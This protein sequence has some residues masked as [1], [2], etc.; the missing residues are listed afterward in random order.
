MSPFIETLGWMLIHFLWQAAVIAV[1]LWIVTQFI[2]SA[3]WRYL[4]YCGSML[5]MLACAFVSVVM[6][7]PESKPTMAQA[8]AVA[9][10][11]VPVDM[12][13]TSQ[14]TAELNPP[15]PIN[16]VMPGESSAPMSTAIVGAVQDEIPL[17]MASWLPWVVA[18]WAV[19][20]AILS[21]N[22][23]RSW[24]ALRR[25][26]SLSDPDTNA[27][28]VSVFARLLDRMGLTRQVELRCS[29]KTS[30]PLVVGW[31]RPAVI[32]P[33]SL[34]ARMPSWQVEAIL[35]HELAHI[36]RHDYL[37]N[38][39]QNVVETIF[40]YH[41]AVWWVSNQIRKER[42][43]CCDDTAAAICGNVVDYAR[44]LTSLEE[45]RSDVP[46]GALS[47]ASGP[48]LGRVRRLLGAS[49]NDAA[50]AFSWP[51]GVAVA[52]LVAG[53]FASVHFVQGQEP[54]DAKDEKVDPT[55]RAGSVRGLPLY[56]LPTSDD[57]TKFDDLYDADGKRKPNVFFQSLGEVGPWLYY[58]AGAAHFYLSVRPDPEV[59]KDIVYGP[60]PGRPVE[61]LDLA[62]WLRES[63]N[64]PDPS[65][66]RRVAHRMIR[67]GD[68]SLAM[69]SF[70]WILTFEPPSPPREY[71]SL[72][73]EVTAYLR[74]H[75]GSDKAKA[76]SDQLARM[77]AESEIAWDKKREQLADELY[78]SGVAGS[79][80]TED[81][82]KIRWSE[83]TD[84][85]LRLGVAGVEEGARWR[86]GDTIVLDVFV[87]NSSSDPLRFA[88][89]PRID[90]GLSLQLTDAE[91]NT[92]Q[93]QITRFSGWI[94]HQ[95]GE[96]A[97]SEM[98]K[99]KSGAAFF[100]GKSEEDVRNRFPV[101]TPGEYS[102]RVSCQLGINDWKGRDGQEIVRPAGEWAG[103]VLSDAMPVTIIDA[104]PKPAAT[105]ADS[106]T[107]SVSGETWSEENLTELP[108]GEPD[109]HGLR[110]ARFFQPQQDRYEIGDRVDGRIVFHNTGAES[111]EFVTED[112]HQRETWHCTK[113][114]GEK[115][116]PWIAERMGF[117]GYPRFRLAPGEVCTVGAQGVKIGRVPYDDEPGAVFT[118][119]RLPAEAGD[120]FT[121]AWDV[122]LT[123]AGE[124]ESTL[125]SGDFV[126]TTTKFEPD[127]PLELGIARYLGKYHLAD[128]IKLQRSQ[129][130]TETMAIIEW[131]SG[132]RHRIDLEH[133]DRNEPLVPIYWW[134]GGTVLW[135]AETDSVRKVDFSDSAKVQEI[136]WDW[137]EA[138]EDFG[139]AP[140]QVQ[141]QIRSERGHAELNERFRSF[142][143]IKSGELLPEEKFA[144]LPFGEPSEN[145]LRVA[146]IF[147][148]MQAE[149]RVGD[150]L[151][152]RI[153]FHNSGD[154]P[155]E[156]RTD[157]WHQD[158]T[159]HVTDGN[160]DDI[161]L[162]PVWFTGVTPYQRYRL[163]PGE[164]CEVAG[165]GVGIG[166][167]EF[168]EAT[169]QAQMGQQILA[170]P[171]DEVHCR[172]DV[173]LRPSWRKSDGSETE[174]ESLSTGK[175][176]FRVLAALPVGERPPGVAKGTGSFDLALG[177]TLNL[178]TI[179]SREGYEKLAS[180]RWTD[181]AGSGQAKIPLVQS[182]DPKD[183]S[184]PT[185]VWP[186]GG[187]ALWILQPDKL[188]KI[189][190]SKV[191]EIEEI[192]WPWEDAPDDFGGAPENVQ[193]RIRE[194]KPAVK[195]TGYRDRSLREWDEML[196]TAK[197]SDRETLKALGYGKP[198][199]AIPAEALPTLLALVKTGQN[200]TKCRCLGTLK[201]LENP[202]DE[203][204]DT[205]I[206]ALADQMSKGNRTR[207]A[208]LL[209]DYQKR[210][211]YIVP[212]LLPLLQN[213]GAVE[214]ET[215]AFAL[216]R[217]GTPA[218]DALP[219]LQ[220]KLPGASETL[221]QII[222]T[223]I[224]RIRDTAAEVKD[225]AENEGALLMVSDANTGEAIEEFLVLAG[226]PSGASRS[227][228]NDHKPP[229]VNW[230]SH[231]IKRGSGGEF[232]WPAD[233]GYK[234][235]ALRI[236]ADG[237]VP[238]V[239][240]G[241]TKGVNEVF[242]VKLRSDSGI[243]GSVQTPNGK[244]PA[245]DAT[246]VLAMIRRN[247]RLKGTTFPELA[248]S[249]GESL[250]DQWDQ[251][252][253]VKPDNQGRFT[254]PDEPDPTAVILI[255]HND[256]V[257]ERRFSE[258]KKAPDVTLEPWARVHGKIL[259][260]NQP[261][262][263]EKVDLIVNRGDTY[264][265]PD[266]VAQYDSTVADEKGQFVFER[267]LP[268]LAQLSRPFETVDAEGN[269]LTAYVEGHYTHAVLKAPHTPVLLGGY[270][271]KVTG[272]LTGLDDTEGVT[273]S[274]HPNAPH[275][276]SPGDE[277]M[278][279]A[280]SMLK[281][282][283]S[284]PKYFRDGLKVEADGSFEI[285]GV[286][287]GTYQIFFARD[288]RIASGKFQVPPEDRD[289]TD[290]ELLDIGEF[291]VRK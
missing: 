247:A 186:R 251:P 240:H 61:K 158:D 20:V 12:A 33:V 87:C 209:G 190:F 79:M 184:L 148:P 291:K 253:V 128:G 163:A 259:W 290:Q 121:C 262:A 54:N 284:G 166:V 192:N 256:G 201:K 156:F 208:Y 165:H 2:R 289:H 207:A 116:D 232:A 107:S 254:L 196:A 206:A 71:A 144:D 275:I 199:V 3:R 227:F 130:P 213:D 108:F 272:K 97:P 193:E 85:P 236:E 125:R 257:F 243:R 214:Q 36:R 269:K 40:F 27:S 149:Y 252:V 117:R 203:V 5:A 237:Y 288:G 70:D 114:G 274:F 139:G 82:R 104:D 286:L 235:M 58:R 271:R 157:Q 66:A 77:T 264:G 123:Y 92:L 176:S 31:I 189:D 7:W 18:L 25:L 221:K 30:V 68:E 223:A 191:G 261:G 90:E 81:G 19:G 56:G 102:L 279:A 198:E 174:P 64:H 8:V 220:A 113:N 205:V 222:E 53:L 277:A 266:I 46:A 1:L 6:H 143:E 75:P 22:F 42:E 11:S 103:E 39:L 78:Q 171:G 9:S 155:V 84:S 14:P 245:D 187:S 134:R 141:E 60:I 211:D 132:E 16:V 43:H 238:Q 24:K 69:T 51:V 26:R 145:G 109:R 4:L 215:A 169:S 250:R 13:A 188:R 10:P 41:P 153:I 154:G 120:T 110:V 276:G 118:T 270:G 177:V 119:V 52:L 281:D 50:A 136:P 195:E 91:G 241:L 45:L 248:L 249:K 225:D 287:P 230:Q 49:Q 76:V 59:V 194:N 280:W 106:A 202:S 273:F 37:V 89:T 283:P 228:E 159:W 80:R 105:S 142:E 200:A 131:D 67:S 126:F 185:M 137:S 181:P 147:D 150:V 179:G 15:G 73:D 62:G 29:E 175:V 17:G 234:E 151:K 265:Y 95:R 212:R 93:A 285:S 152:C 263:G 216:G 167:A 124:E 112:W 217:I 72:L 63:P 226:V 98:L 111:V 231:T 255:L 100:I 242:N 233:R 135:I 183:Y 260:G 172:W 224:E 47:A 168:A 197:N 83:E 57:I 268:G 162:R 146:W 258:W 219:A 161:P 88:W 278:W 21:L 127:H 178:T 173:R 282:S 115:V 35:A 34:F 96:L 160:G 140:E 129:S 32:V 23:L 180:I 99:V 229:V 65:Y 101:E 246:V 28:T 164:T 122:T 94:V 138:P 133:R 74:E 210:S 38:L 218:K 48:L 244:R 182:D 44:A 55:N 239:I 204:L 267:V 86:I 170:K